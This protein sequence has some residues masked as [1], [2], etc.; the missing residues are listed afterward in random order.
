MAEFSVQL[1]I[2]SGAAAILWSSL[3]GALMLIPLQAHEPKQS[4]GM[5]FKQIGAAHLDC[6]MLGLIHGARRRF[7]LVVRS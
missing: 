6:I 2:F 7:D 5:N 4:K 3:L 1:L